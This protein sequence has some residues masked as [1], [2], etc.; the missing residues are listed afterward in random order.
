LLR[1]LRDRGKKPNYINFR[2]T[3]FQ[4]L[5][6]FQNLKKTH[7]SFIQSNPTKSLMMVK[8]IELLMVVVLARVDGS[9]VVMMFG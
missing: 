9:M 4:I 5:L 1:V 6:Q 2:P 7:E 8:V 3:S